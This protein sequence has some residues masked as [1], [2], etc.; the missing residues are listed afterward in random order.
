MIKLETPLGPLYI[1]PE[2][3][4]AITP[5]IGRPDCSVIYCGLFPNGVSIDRSPLDILELIIAAQE[6]GEPDEEE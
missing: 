3:I 6:I 5:E 1:R 4:I 2:D